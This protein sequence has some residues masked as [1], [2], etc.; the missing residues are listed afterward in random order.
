M[1]YRV[2]SNE[3][4][5]QLFHAPISEQNTKNISTNSGLY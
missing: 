2:V 3:D 5:N 1:L 4:Q